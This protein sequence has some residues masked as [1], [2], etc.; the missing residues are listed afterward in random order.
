MAT[1]A[2]G[3]ASQVPWDLV[4]LGDGE[5][6]DQ[7]LMLRERHGLTHCVH[8]P[9]FRQYDQ[10]PPYYALAAA[11]IHPS[12]VEPWGLVVNEAMASGLPVLVSNRCGCAPTLVHDGENGRT[13]DPNDSDE[14][15]DCML[16]MTRLAPELRQNMGCRSRQIVAEFG[17]A[18]FAEGLLA[19][20]T[21]ALAS[22][23]KDP[24][25]VDRLVLKSL[26]RRSVPRHRR[27]A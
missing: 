4:L 23:A 18:K 25:L 14:M 10:L 16:E 7:L 5:L 15:T 27:I 19:A 21:A 3:T 20:A 9:G 26:L 12:T 2:A 11:F 1:T 8:L 6:R 24:R 22:R 17:P 13:F